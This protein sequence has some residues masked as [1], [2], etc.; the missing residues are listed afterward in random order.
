VKPKLAKPEPLAVKQATPS[1]DP[2]K[3]KT[4]F[5]YDPNAK[6]STS[7][8]SLGGTRW[9]GSFDTSGTLQAPV[10]ISFNE[11]R[12]YESNTLGEGTWTQSGNT[13]SLVQEAGPDLPAQYTHG[14]RFSISGDQMTLID[15]QTQSGVRF[16]RMTLTKKPR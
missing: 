8:G 10:Y 13:V 15:Q 2:S 4:T 11:G 5:G 16:V 1:S 14:T 7:V 9:D 12:Q 3:G 6:K